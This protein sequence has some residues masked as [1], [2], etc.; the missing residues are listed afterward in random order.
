LTDTEFWRMTLHEVDV[1]ACRW[2][3]QQARRDRGTAM[4]IQVLLNVNRDTQHR[5]EP[6]TLEEVM[7]ALGHQPPAPPP[8]PVRTPEEIAAQ[9]AVLHSFYALGNGQVQGL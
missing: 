9:I 3:D 5:R 7:E 6:F 1:L 4:L 2:R 8:P